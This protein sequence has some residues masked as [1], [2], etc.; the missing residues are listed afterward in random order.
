MSIVAQRIVIA[1]I[2]L[3]PRWGIIGVGIA[4]RVGQSSL[5]I[6]RPLIQLLRVFRLDGPWAL[7]G[8]R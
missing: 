5:T 8:A 1:R 7:E 2:Q 4:W 6:V 3:L